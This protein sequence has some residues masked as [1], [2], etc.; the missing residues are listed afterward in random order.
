MNA[1]LEPRPDAAPGGWGIV[2]VRIAGA[3][4]RRTYAYETDQPLMIGEWVT[5]PGNVVSEHGGFGIVKS[6]GRDGYTGPLKKIRARIP[7][8]P[9]LMI[10][11]SVVK[12]KDRAADIYDAAVA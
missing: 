11:M 4:A 1:E 3:T 9:E 8:P 6:Y 7:E 12:T 5:L 10:M 2:Q